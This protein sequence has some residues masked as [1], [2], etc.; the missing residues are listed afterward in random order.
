MFSFETKS[1]CRMLEHIDGSDSCS[2]RLILSIGVLDFRPWPGLE[3]ITA[4]SNH[5]CLQSTE[6]H[7][8]P[9]AHPINQFPIITNG[10]QTVFEGWGDIP[11]P[12]YQ[13]PAPSCSHTHPK[14]LGNGLHD[15][16]CSS[17][18]QSSGRC[19]CRIGWC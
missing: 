9:V 13:G 8:F 5:I 19:F 10:R 18:G 16:S 15:L 6:Y 3:P 4:S 7:L 1:E 12:P 11:P 17:F 14:H 2:G